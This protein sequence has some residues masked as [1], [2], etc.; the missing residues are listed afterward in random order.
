MPQTPACH[1]QQDFTQVAIAAHTAAMAAA[2][3][4]AAA[5]QA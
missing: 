2:A 1:A 3:A 4:A 5:Q